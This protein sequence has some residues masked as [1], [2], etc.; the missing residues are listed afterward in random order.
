M[1]KS[2]VNPNIF[3]LCTKDPG[4]T[5]GLHVIDGCMKVQRIKCQATESF[6][7]VVH[8][9]H[10]INKAF[11]TCSA[12]PVIGNQHKQ[13]D[14]HCRHHQWFHAFTTKH[15]N[16]H[17]DTVGTWD[18]KNMKATED[19][20]LFIVQWQGF[21]K[22]TMENKANIPFH[23]LEEFQSTGSVTVSLTNDVIP[24]Y[25][26]TGETHPTPS[27]LDL[28]LAGVTPVFPQRPKKVKRQAKL[29]IRRGQEIVSDDFK[30]VDD[31]ESACYNKPDK[32][33]SFHDKTA[34]MIQQLF[35]YKAK[36]S[37]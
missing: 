32:W 7:R 23:I 26:P 21:E 15:P 4:C 18:I 14:K 22:P 29:G 27:D 25:K 12:T 24:H 36:Q 9:D 6:C 30:D 11:R 5:K 34:G 16:A 2:E 10:H 8:H 17:P 1:V 20:D 37:L 3:R 13:S 31:F 33:Q 35:H 19:P 28:D